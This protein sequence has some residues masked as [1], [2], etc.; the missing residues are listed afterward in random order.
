[1]AKT[2]RVYRRQTRAYR[3]AEILEHMRLLYHDTGQA[4][5]YSTT[6]LARLV[7][8]RPSVHFTS[9]LEEL[10]RNGDIIGYATPHR[11]GQSSVKKVHHYC[12]TEKQCQAVDLFKHTRQQFHCEFVLI[13]DERR[14]KA[15]INVHKNRTA[16]KINGVDVA[17]GWE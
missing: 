7:D 8:L 4:Y 9:L 5:W 11:G 14:S 13:H 2:G 1:M 3:K 15:R 17:S 16:L 12:L 10:Y 6:Q